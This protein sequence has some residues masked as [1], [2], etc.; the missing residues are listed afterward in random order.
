MSDINHL[1]LENI[2]TL[3]PYNVLN[4][5]M[6]KTTTSYKNAIKA[7]NMGD[8]KSFI[9]HMFQHRQNVMTLHNLLSSP[10]TFLTNGKHVSDRRNASAKYLR[11]FLTPIG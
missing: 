3:K 9:D 7:H 2:E 6:R 1:I 5:L 4:N 10:K 8:S 11:S